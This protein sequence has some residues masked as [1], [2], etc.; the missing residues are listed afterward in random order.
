MTSSGMRYS[1]IDP[2]HDSSAR[3]L[4]VGVSERPSLNQCSGG[5]CPVAIATKLVSRASD[6]SKS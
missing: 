5:T 2:L 6:A 4:P 1:N 3:S